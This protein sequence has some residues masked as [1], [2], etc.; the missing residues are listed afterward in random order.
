MKFY[1][2][3]LAIEVSV[4]E[5]EG[6]VFAVLAHEGGNGGCLVRKPEEV[7]RDTG[8]L[9]YLN[10]HGRI[11]DA[12]TKAKNQ[13]AEVLEDVHPIGPHGFRALIRDSEGNRLALHSEVDA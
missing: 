8:I 12:V 7:A 2:E 1:Q 6:M 3:V 11:R 9:L 5:F 10:V 4:H 13:G